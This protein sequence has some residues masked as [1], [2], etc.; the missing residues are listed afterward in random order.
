MLNVLESGSPNLLL[1]QAKGQLTAADRAVF[2]GRLEEILHHYGSVRVFLDLTNL[3]GVDPCSEWDDPVSC[4]RWKD[5]VK[6]L[7]VVCQ[8][9]DQ[10]MARN[11]TEPFVNVRF[12]PL[13]EW[14]EAWNWVAEGAEEEI[15]K[16]FIRH[17]A[18]AKWQAAG[19]PEGDGLAFWV[20]AEKELRHVG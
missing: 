20:E 18:Y 14:E 15:N 12:F 6:R 7:A 1:L 11:V 16:E 10:P 8:P 17:L 13:S 4:L 19:C 9:V 2:R 3:E 5:A